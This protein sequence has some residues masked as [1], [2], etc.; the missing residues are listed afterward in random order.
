M[1]YHGDTE[2]RSKL[3]YEGLTEKIIKRR[4]SQKGFVRR[5]GFLCVSVSPW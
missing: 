4:N 5:I 2:A 3:L 1:I